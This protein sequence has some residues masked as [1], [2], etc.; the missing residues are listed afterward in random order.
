MSASWAGAFS[1][2]V[3]AI[4]WQSVPVSSW[5]VSWGLLLFSKW[6][7]DLVAWWLFP[8]PGH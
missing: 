7:E 1:Q 2:S 6:L 4:F 8:F 5:R 3:V